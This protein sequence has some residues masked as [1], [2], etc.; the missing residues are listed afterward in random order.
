MVVRITPLSASHGRDLLTRPRV[1]TADPPPPHSHRVPQSSAVSI[2]SRLKFKLMQVLEALEARYFDSILPGY[3]VASGA[4]ALVLLFV[5]APLGRFS[6]PSWGPQLNAKVRHYL[7]FR[8]S[9]K[10]R[11][12]DSV[13]TLPCYF[14]VVCLVYYGITHNFLLGLVS[15]DG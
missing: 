2:S 13:L 8:F 12:C 4:T 6:S 7:P 3:F 9:W 15:H 11:T 1:D 5:A 14:S 10:Q